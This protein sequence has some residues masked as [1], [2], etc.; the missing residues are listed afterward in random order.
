MFEHDEY[1]I[2]TTDDNLQKRHV[3]ITESNIQ[4]ARELAE[5]SSR[6]QG[7]WAVTYRLELASNVHLTVKDG[8]RYPRL[9]SRGYE[10]WVSCADGGLEHPVFFDSMLFHKCIGHGREPEWSFADTKTWVNREHRPT[11][12]RE[13]DEYAA[14]YDES[15]ISVDW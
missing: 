1:H 2:Y 13:F 14:N 12:E 15:D 5:Q 6:V 3:H 8:N 10:G 7:D 9:E 11:F 4:D